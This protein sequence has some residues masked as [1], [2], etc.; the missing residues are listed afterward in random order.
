MQCSKMSRNSQTWH[1]GT[2]DKGRETIRK[3]KYQRRYDIQTWHDSD[4]ANV[5]TN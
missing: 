1:S 3:R 4:A 2:H 5:R